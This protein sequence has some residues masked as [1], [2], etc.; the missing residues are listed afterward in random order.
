MTDEELDERLQEYADQ[1]GVTV[2]DITYGQDREYIRASELMQKVVDWLRGQVTV[3]EAAETEA[4]LAPETEAET[5][6]AETEAET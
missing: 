5:V 6:T 4:E 3:E 1:Y 2:E